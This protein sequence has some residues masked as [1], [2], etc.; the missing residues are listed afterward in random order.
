MKK[1]TILLGSTALLASL[2]QAQVLMDFNIGGLDEFIYGSYVGNASYTSFGGTAQGNAVRIGGS[3]RGGGGI[4]NR[5]ASSIDWS[6]YLT[7]RFRLRASR[8]AGNTM[9]N[10]TVYFRE[11]TTSYEYHYSFPASSFP[12]GQLTWVDGNFLNNPSFV[13]DSANGFSFVGAGPDFAPALEQVT[14]VGIQSNYVLSDR[15][16]R[17]VLDELHVVP[18]PATIVTLTV[19][20]LAVLRRRKKTARA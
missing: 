15:D 19:G 18:E 10:F 3:S 12:I 14:T 2:G 16:N 1:L 8:E 6:A 4:E 20:A 13:L 5:P 11:A 7:T 9:G 17:L